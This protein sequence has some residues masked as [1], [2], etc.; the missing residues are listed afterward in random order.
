MEQQQT[1]TIGISAC[2]AG[3]KVRYDGS[4][5]RSSFCMDQLGKHVKY[6]HYCPE[7][8][9]GMTIPRPTIRQTQQQERIILAS[10]DGSNDVTDA[11]IDYGKQIAEK[12]DHLSGF[13]FCAKSPS[14]GME[15][16]KVYA[17]SGQS[18]SSNGVGLF[19]AE[20]MAH[21]PLLPCEE[22]G[23]LNDADIRENFIARVYIYHR[24]QQL[25]ASGI[26]RKKLIDFHSQLKYTLMSHD[27]LAVKRLGQILA[28]ASIAVDEQASRYI[29]GCMQTLK[30][31]AT[32]KKHTNTLQHLQGYFADE[33]NSQEREILTDQ[34]H[35]Y[36]QGLVPLLVPI[37][38]LKHY[39]NLYPKSYLQ[40][41]TYFNPYPEDLR[42]RYSQ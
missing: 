32:R 1:I 25:I 27:P 14:C 5:K 18:S 26:S 20:I 23:R 38:Q 3:E 33:L 31:I 28:D 13:I 21:N 12:V 4:A 41:Q 34:I 2:L 17:A 19:A 10:A 16:V 15:R 29:Q 42:L 6:Q 7:V 39:L 22:N 11:M 30:L 37:E 36:R 40:Q 35:R 8:A 24:W 9:V